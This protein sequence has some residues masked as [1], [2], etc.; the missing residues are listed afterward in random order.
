MKKIVLFT[1]TIIVS[2][3]TLGFTG[4]I[5]SG[6]LR[7]PQIIG[8]Q[9]N[10]NDTNF[11]TYK[12]CLSERMIQCISLGHPEGVKKE[13]LLKEARKNA[14][15]KEFMTYFQPVASVTTLLVAVYL[16][17]Q[18]GG[19]TIAFLAGSGS[20]LLTDLIYSENNN[21]DLLSELSTALNPN[22]K[23]LFVVEEGIS[24]LDFS[25]K[26]EY[27]LKSLEK[28]TS[29]HQSYDYSNMMIMP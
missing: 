4:V 14:R 9:E 26:L 18:T 6:N 24:I 12:F 15:F 22:R 8:F 10:P 21:T 2:V 28:M 16:T 19:A 13:L 3:N 27:K 1:L 25:Y 29:H 23:G 7:E 5:K 11:I 20:Y 17:I